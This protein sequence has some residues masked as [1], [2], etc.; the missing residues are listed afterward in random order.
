MLWGIIAGVVLLGLLIGAVL[1]LHSPQEDKPQVRRC[2]L[3]RARLTP[4]ETVF[5]QVLSS[6]PPQQ[7][8][9]KGCPHCLPNYYGDTMELET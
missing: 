4:G 9:I 1:F 3:C 2:P 8:K 5:A 7:I 6:G